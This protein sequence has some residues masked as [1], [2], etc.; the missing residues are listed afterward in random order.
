MAFIGISAIWYAMKQLREMTKARSLTAFFEAYKYIEAEEPVKLRRFMYELSKQ[1]GTLSDEERQKFELSVRNW[2]VVAYL[3][4][5][6]FV[7]VNEFLEFYFMAILKYWSKAQPHVEFERKMRKDPTWA[8]ALEWL[9][10]KTETY[11]S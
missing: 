3:V 5:K 7:P 1:P 10:N 6:N 11:R 9:A 4:R 8:P 2:D